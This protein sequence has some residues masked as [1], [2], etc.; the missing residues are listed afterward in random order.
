MDSLLFTSANPH[1]PGWVRLIATHG[2]RVQRKPCET[3][4][5][6]EERVSKIWSTDV[7]LSRVWW[8]LR[9]KLMRLAGH[10]SWDLPWVRFIPLAGEDPGMA[11]EET[12]DSLPTV[13]LVEDSE[14]EEARE[15]RTVMLADELRKVELAPTIEQGDGAT[16]G[17]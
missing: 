10:S 2:E 1:L 14:P 11:P 7:E 4:W 12:K 16:L 9:E 5:P 8:F 13:T 3:D 15:K 17:T 6:L